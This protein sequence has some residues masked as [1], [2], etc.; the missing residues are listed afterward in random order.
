[1]C[2]LIETGR[3]AELLELYKQLIR[4]RLEI[5]MG[6]QILQKEK[7]IL[8]EKVAQ[9]DTGNVQE[10][11]KSSATWEKGEWLG[12]KEFFLNT[13]RRK[14]RAIALGD[15]SIAVLYKRSF[16]RAVEQIQRQ[17]QERIGLFLKSIPYFKSLTMASVDKI[18]SSME[19]IEMQKDQLASSEYFDDDRAEDKEDYVYFV[20]SGEFVAVMQMVVHDNGQDP[21]IQK[22]KQYKNYIHTQYRQQATEASIHTGTVEILPD[23]RQDGSGSRLMLCADKLNEYTTKTVILG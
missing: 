4:R 13:S 16:D 11:F 17:K 6:M 2:D 7:D 22:S 18:A 14:R 10:K 12:E 23:K 19:T 1:M 8:Q 15:C 9:I 3:F 20:K 21:L 5:Q